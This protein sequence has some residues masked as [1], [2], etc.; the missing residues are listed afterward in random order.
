MT[1][2]L[3]LCVI[4]GSITLWRMMAMTHKER[5]AKIELGK[6]AD[7]IKNARGRRRA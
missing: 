5:M 2:V 4:F 1:P 3:I 7:A 6:G